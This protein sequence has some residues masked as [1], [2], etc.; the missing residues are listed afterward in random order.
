VHTNRPAPHEPEERRDAPTA[1]RAG[2][3]RG[4][5]RNRSS[6]G[7]PFLAILA[8]C[9]PGR[10]RLFGKQTLLFYHAAWWTPAP[11][12]VID[13]RHAEHWPAPAPG[14]CFD[15]Q[16]FVPRLVALPRIVWDRKRVRSPE[17]E[18]RFRNLCTMLR[19]K[20]VPLVNPPQLSRL[21][22]DKWE[23]HRFLL[24]HHLP[25]PQ[26]E[27][28]T[29]AAL[30]RWLERGEPFWIKPRRGSLGQGCRLVLPHARG[31]R[32]ILPDG[33]RI[34]AS[35]EEIRETAPGS[36]APP[37]LLLQRD[38]RPP[39][40]HG[41]RWDVRLLIQRTPAGA[42]IPAW[43]VGRV[44]APDQ[45]TT[46][47][48]RGGR[49]LPL[50]QLRRELAHHPLAR[51]PWHHELEQ[52]TASICAALEQRWPTLHELIIEL[53]VDLIL[54]RNGRWS[55]LELNVKPGHGAHHLD[56]PARGA[57]IRE[58]LIRTLLERMHALAFS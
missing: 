33:R 38:C 57:R 41:R 50:E 15:G 28:L 17:D 11:L 9:F 21:T 55:I 53:A 6:S 19:A 43:I 26:T 20:H 56:D 52:L 51:R 4:A 35:P 24:E 42:W 31:A 40:L 18:Q 48:A 49:F 44:A 34:S 27:L 5:D 47:R 22:G 39:P 46:N 1:R 25:A 23:T 37:D 8:P 54:D 7:A 29:P 36:A 58:R 14:W 12:A 3:G 13:P 16:E 30:E 10:P 32:V 45:V 2:D